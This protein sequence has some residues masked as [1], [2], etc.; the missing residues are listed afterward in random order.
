MDHIIKSLIGITDIT[1]D[2]EWNLRIVSLKVIRK[3][4]ELEHKNDFKPAFEWADDWI[5][6]KEQ[7]AEQQ[8]LLISLDVVN[9]ICNLIGQESKLAIKEEA[10]LVSVA[11]LL[12]GNPKSQHKFNEY[13]L[14]DTQNSFMMS[15]KDM[16]FESFE[17]V[18]KTQIKRNNGKMKL[19]QVK[20]KV[21]ELGELKQKNRQIND[22]IKKAR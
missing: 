14:S 8:S 12:G 6:Y 15:I 17:M 11:I 19:I 7:I 21:D 3:V 2:I 13:I 10:L 4:V 9:L 1:S 5:K 20:K 18:K 22:E 16:I